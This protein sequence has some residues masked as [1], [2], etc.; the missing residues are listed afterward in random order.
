M[1]EAEYLAAALY[2]MTLETVYVHVP[3]VL[4]RSGGVRLA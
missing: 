3:E 4:S 2:R 1:G